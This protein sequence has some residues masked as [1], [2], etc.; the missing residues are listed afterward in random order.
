MVTATGWSGGADSMGVG[1][2]D[3]VADGNGLVLGLALALGVA[4]GSPVEVQPT[5]VPASAQTVKATRAVEDKLRD[6]TPTSSPRQADP[7]ASN[8]AKH[9]PAAR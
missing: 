7:A 6:N 5:R 9:Q 8:A 1:D 2:S 3:G 4:R